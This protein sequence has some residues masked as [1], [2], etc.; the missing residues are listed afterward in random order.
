VNHPE[1]DGGTSASPFGGGPSVAA[2]VGSMDGKLG[3]YCAHISAVNGDPGSNLERAV[4]S[5]LD[6]FCQRNE[7]NM[8]RT[9][10][11]YRGGVAENQI[12]AVL[13]KELHA[14]KAALMARGYGEGYVKIAIVMCQKRHHAR[15]VYETQDHEYANPCVGLCI[16]ASNVYRHGQLDTGE[17]DCVGNVNSADV[18]EFYLNS[19]AAVLGTS[20]PCKYTL[21]YD[22]I[23]LK[24]ISIIFF[25]MRSIT[26]CDFEVG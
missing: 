15:F 7:G 12:E 19:H 22:E 24:V 10:I 8:P 25:L 21:I 6:T 2:V 26:Y 17:P 23:G 14:F 4:S 16:D 1:I 11:I 18:N 20:K 9:M 13:E 3:Q 5:L